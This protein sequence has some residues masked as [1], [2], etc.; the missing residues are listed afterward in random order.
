MPP[1]VRSYP[2]TAGVI[3]AAAEVVSREITQAVEARGRAWV[4]LSGGETPRAL[5]TRLAES[6]GAV[7][8]EKVWWCF[9]D[10]RWVRRDDPLSNFAMVDNALFSRAPI[11][12][13][14][15]VPVPTEASDPV[16]GARAYDHALRAHCAGAAWPAFDVVLLGLGADGHIASLFPRDPALEERTRW[17][18]TT[19]AGQPVPDRV[20]LTV[21]V[22]AHARVTVFLVAGASKSDAVAATLTGPRDPVRWPGQAV[23]PTSGRCTWLLDHDAA[24]KL[25]TDSVRSSS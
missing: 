23:M 20:T 24:A 5:Y 10:E 4:V 1:M 15:V 14:Q 18:T 8:W 25:P 13:D 11:P 7:P 2:D 21:P 3:A 16:E 9:G 6:S 22:F 19:R 17:V 12:R